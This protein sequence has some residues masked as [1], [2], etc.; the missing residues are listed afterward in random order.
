MQ[1]SRKL[2]FDETPD[3]NWL[4]G[5]FVQVLGEIGEQDDGIF[6]WTLINDGKGW[7]SIAKEK[8]H[9]SRKLLLPP[10]LPSHRNGQQREGFRQIKQE[11]SNAHQ[12]LQ[13]S[14]RHHHQAYY[15]S[16][17]NNKT[18]DNSSHSNASRSAWAKLKS[19]LTCGIF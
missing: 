11:S 1:Y 8:K 13:D 12:T 2:G 19:L 6:D 17:P 7:Q 5:L 15:N 18:D 14:S 3:Y 16:L 9:T 4:R 10:P